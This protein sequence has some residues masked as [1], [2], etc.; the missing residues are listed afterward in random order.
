MIIWVRI[1]TKK[2]KIKAMFFFFLEI[3][4][5]VKVP[6]KKVILILPSV[7]FGGGW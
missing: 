4:T 2:I 7:D 3:I 5:I 6:G 1:R